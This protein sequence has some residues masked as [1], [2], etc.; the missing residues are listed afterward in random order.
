MINTNSNL[1]SQNLISDDDCFSKSKLVNFS[2]PRQNSM[3]NS[4][5]K[6]IIMLDFS[7]FDRNQTKIINSKTINLHLII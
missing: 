5:I 6:A 2:I 4:G 3:T 7:I 1:N